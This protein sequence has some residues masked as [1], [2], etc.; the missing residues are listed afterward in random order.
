MQE[1]ETEDK[2]EQKYGESLQ[3]EKIM[4]DFKW[5]KMAMVF[6]WKNSDGLQVEKKKM[7]IGFQIHTE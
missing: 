4:M 1:V 5:E 3:V 7:V 6:E 2:Q